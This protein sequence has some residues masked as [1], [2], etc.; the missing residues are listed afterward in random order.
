[1]KRRF[2]TIAMILMVSICFADVPFL[3]YDFEDLTSAPYQY[4]IQTVLGTGTL[5]LT[6][7]TMT[8][9]SA[10]L[11]YNPVTQL[12]DGRAY[13]SSNYPIATAPSSTH[14][15]QI[16][17]STVGLSDIKL[18]WNQR[19]AN[20]MSNRTRIQ[21]TID[22]IVWID[23]EA[24][25]SNSE[26]FFLSSGAPEIIYD[27]GLLINFHSWWF[28]RSVDFSGIPEVNN[29]ANFGIRI[30]AAHP[31]G[32][33]SYA[34]IGN[35]YNGTGNVVFD[36]IIFTHYTPV[37]S[38]F[39]SV[40]SGLKLSPF[41]V[42][43]A[44]ETESAEIY[45]TLDGAEPDEIESNLYT[46][47]IEIDSTTTLKFIAVK[48]DLPSSEIQTVEYR[49]PVDVESIV[50]LHS[51][52]PDTGEIY[53][54]TNEVVVSMSLDDG[55]CLYVQDNEDIENREGIKITDTEL[56]L[57]SQ[58]NIG[59]GFVDIA[60]MLCTDRGMLIF[61]PIIDSGTLLN[62]EVHITP[63]NVTL[64]EMSENIE[65]YQSMLLLI[66]DVQFEEEGVFETDSVYPIYDPTG[67]FVCKT[68]W[69]DADYIGTDVP[70]ERLNLIAILSIEDDIAY[71]T[72]RFLLDMEIIP[73]DVYNPPR[74]ANFSI[75][76][77]VV[78]LDWLAPDLE[79]NS[80]DFLESYNV[81]RDDIAIATDISDA[82]FDDENVEAEQTYIYHITAN[83]D[84]GFES[85]P[86]N[87]LVVY[88]Q[89]T[90]D[91]ETPSI[92]TALIGNYPNPF[93]PTTSI[94]FSVDSSSS[95]PVSISIYNI[96]GQLVRSL[97]DDVFTSGE[98][99]VV[100][101]G[102]D[103]NGISVGSGIYFYRFTADEY[104][105]TRKMIMI[106]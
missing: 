35:I 94:L 28:F 70:T 54:I 75:D 105:Q 101:N 60:G 91:R 37:S 34:S 80:L 1:M 17:T 79:T 2:F 71:L 72:P 83:Y 73:P 68:I 56:V 6:V 25:E 49:F 15:I 29:N 74:E 3:A 102:T 57:T 44:C 22:S 93:N 85:E 4:P 36:N 39:A 95:T 106:K 23:Y 50:A 47:P 69:A 19:S 20:I 51:E 11:G 9:P 77:G 78:K 30:V 86:S 32:Q 76:G 62:T 82:F 65:I 58:F 33:N 24:N 27:N 21:Y 53:R 42:S 45:Y 103:N 99:S 55:H 98:H 90:S 66:E 84:G 16:L 100:W 40:E 97:V 59:D 52:T 67:D 48:A 64:A 63:L 8:N 81:Y 14:G 26:N 18:S 89:P 92:R 43:L 96:R 61:I 41:T 87:V 7:S 31:S 104:V 46:E 10:S 13:S 38:P 88:V 12:D 5:S